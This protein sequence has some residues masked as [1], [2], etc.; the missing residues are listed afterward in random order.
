MKRNLLL[1]VA[2][3]GIALA[4]SYTLEEAFKNGSFSGDIGT[5]FEDRHVTEGR[6]T[7]YYNNTSWAVGSIALNYQ[8]DLLYNLRFAT[9]FRGSAP[10]YEDDENFMTAHGRGDASERIYRDDRVLLSRLYVEYSSGGTAIRI[11]RQPINTDW[12]TKINDAIRITSTSVRNLK[13]DIIWSRARGRA[14]LKEMFGF[15]R[16]NPKQ[17][18][19]GVANVGI[20]YKFNDF[21]SLKGYGLHAESIFHGAGAKAMLDFPA[22][23]ELTF[24]ALAHF[25]MSDEKHSRDLGSVAEGQVYL[26]FLGTKLALA[27]VQSGRKIGRGSLGITGDLITPFEEGDVM[28]ARD[29]STVYG[30]LS[31]S[32]DNLSI[33]AAYGTTEYKRQRTPTL[34]DDK[35]YRQSELS[36]WLNHAFTRH[37]KGLLTYDR[38]F[39]AQPGY[40]SLTQVSVG[41]SYSF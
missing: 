6:Q 14:Y 1:F 16:T 27:Y 10:F 24:G 40:P 11:G 41:M 4:N 17:N 33:A 7:Q 19:S 39:K 25:A 15:Q 5:Y 3:A 26:K 21:F 13:I 23:R 8:T 29:T 20:T 28:Y 31:T 34:D 32:I 35:N 9:G 22:N 12:M 38:T 2:C 36:I 37:F 30:L 18:H